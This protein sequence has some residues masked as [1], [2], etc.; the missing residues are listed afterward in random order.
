MIY[1]YPKSR[2]ERTET[3]REYKDYGSY[4]RFLR[5]EFFG[6]CVYCCE[7]DSHRGSDQF[8]TDH[9][10][11]KVL[12][13]ELEVVYSNLFY[14]CNSCNSRKGNFWPADDEAAARFIPNPCAHIMFAHL[15]F[16]HGE[17][18][19]RTEAGSFT[20]DL[21]DLND[22][23][24]VEYRENQIHMEEIAIS[25]LR[26]IDETVAQLTSAFK[27]GSL[28]AEQFAE[29]ESEI[30]RERLKTSR[31]LKQLRGQDA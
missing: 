29:A 6:R 10:R 25:R 24:Y 13:P 5:T 23:E 15:K 3:P 27:A 31:V 4:K 28:S 11:P 20:V 12:F 14:C 21:L 22:P 7:P 8:G 26:D 1:A 19:P 30:D 9:Y 16:K 18:E 2:H 17:V